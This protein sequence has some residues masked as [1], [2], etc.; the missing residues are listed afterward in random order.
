[1]GSDY[2][3]HQPLRK[4]SLLLSHFISSKITI[5]THLHL[6][7]PPCPNQG[8]IKEV[9]ESPEASQKTKVPQCAV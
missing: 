7:I 9:R 1:M 4:H 6:G 3:T 8:F 5:K 2:N